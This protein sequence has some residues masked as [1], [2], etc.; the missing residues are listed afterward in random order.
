MKI[1]DAFTYYVA[2]NPIPH[3]NAYYAYTTLYEHWIAKF[4]LPE[5]LVTD[6]GTEFINNE[7]ITLCQLYNIKHKQRTSHAPWT[8][9]L[10]KGM[11]RSLQEYL[12]GIING[13]AINLFLLIEKEKMTDKIKLSRPPDL[14]SKH[15]INQIF[16]FHDPLDNLSLSKREI[17]SIFLPVTEKNNTETTTKTQNLDPVIRQ[18]KSWHKYKTKPVKA[19]ISFLRNKTHLRYFYNLK[20]KH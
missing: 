7:I 19:D 11:N 4:G 10:V 13:K 15:T 5:I 17:E 20:T 2:L 6:I 12:R 8:N 1:V 16:V 9:V 14:D 18:L 3:C